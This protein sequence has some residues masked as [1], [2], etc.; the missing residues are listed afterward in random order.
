M[1]Y[2]LRDGGQVDTDRELDFEQRNFIQK[3]LIYS[4][5]KMGLEEFRQRWRQGG[6]SVWRGPETLSAPSP[7]ARIILDLEDRIKSRPGR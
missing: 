5:L 6:N 3:M 4:H 2:E 7:A 1:I